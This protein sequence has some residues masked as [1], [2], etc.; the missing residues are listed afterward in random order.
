MYASIAKVNDQE[1]DAFV[2]RTSW[3]SILNYCGVLTY[4]M[5]SFSAGDRKSFLVKL[6]SLFVSINHS[7]ISKAFYVTPIETLMQKVGD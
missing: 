7:T 6:R 2:F 1:H 3:L 5:D 4:F